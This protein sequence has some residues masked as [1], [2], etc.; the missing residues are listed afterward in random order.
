LTGLE[1]LALESAGVS[2]AVLAAVAILPRRPGVARN[3]AAAYALGL[4]TLVAALGH[5]Q[6]VASEFH[7]DHQATVAARAATSYCVREAGSRVG[8]AFIEWAR[9][10]MPA[11]T[12]YR[13][14]DL[15][16]GPDAWCLTLALLPALP[17]GPGDT[18]PDWEIA[19]G[20]YPP[21][22]KERIAS[23]DRSVKVFVPGFALARLRR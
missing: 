19:F 12:V 13:L 20:G 1:Q 3:H 10:R 6:T 18:A 9:S 16:P 8:A 22:L 23:H 5:L 15:S 4:V 2:A 7:H 21:E 14:D 11:H 17:A